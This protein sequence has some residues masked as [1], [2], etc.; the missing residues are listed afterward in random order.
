MRKAIF[1]FS[2]CLAVC[3]AACNPSDDFLNQLDAVVTEAELHHEEWTEAEWN[4]NKHQYDAL[5]VVRFPEVKAS[6][7]ADQLQ[8]VE[9]MKERYTN[10]T[11]KE[12]PIDG[13]MNIIKETFE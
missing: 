1:F 3:L 5:M 9:L 12:D 11:I 10:V 8:R 6:M 2:V 13:I 7:R 4:L